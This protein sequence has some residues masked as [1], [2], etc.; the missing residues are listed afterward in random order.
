MQN[1]G[2]SVVSCYTSRYFQPN[3]DSFGEKNVFIGPSMIKRKTNIKSFHLILS[4]ESYLYFNG[5]TS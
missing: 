1:K 5:N 3:S 2:V 4:K